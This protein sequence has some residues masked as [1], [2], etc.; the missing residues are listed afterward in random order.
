MIQNNEN[1]KYQK[2]YEYF[3]TELFEKIRPKDTTD[4]ETMLSDGHVRNIST[5]YYY[6]LKSKELIAID[7][8][9]YKLFALE[10]FLNQSNALLD[11]VASALKHFLDLNVSR[12]ISFDNK[13]FTKEIANKLDEFNFPK[14]EE[15]LK[16]CTWVE[17]EIYPYRNLVHHIG[18]CLTWINSTTHEVYVP[19]PTEYDLKKIVQKIR[20]N[21]YPDMTSYAILEEKELILPNY[22]TGEQGSGTKSETIEKLSREVIQKIHRFILFYAEVII[23]YQKN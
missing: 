20:K 15:H 6:L 4:E 10:V 3:K 11:V 18:N 21:N 13:T 2:L 22:I 7:D 12:K 1:R 9:E 17:N 14:K 8:Q 16:Y 23:E 19:D 5:K